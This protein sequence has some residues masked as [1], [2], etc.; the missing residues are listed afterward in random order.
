MASLSIIDKYFQALDKAYNLFTAVMRFTYHKVML[1]WNVM[2]ENGPANHRAIFDR[3]L[4]MPLINENAS[5]IP[6]LS[7]S[8]NW[9]SNTTRY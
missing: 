4:S 8:I 1:Q 5:K 6:P 2:W 9:V 7:K 3:A